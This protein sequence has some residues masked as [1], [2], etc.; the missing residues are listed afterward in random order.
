MSLCAR[1]L[2]A[3]ACPEENDYLLAGP[4]QVPPGEI[5]AL[6]ALAQH[7]RSS[8]GYGPVSRL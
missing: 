4:Y 2:R 6:G 1:G 5:V 7:E 8:R 3:V